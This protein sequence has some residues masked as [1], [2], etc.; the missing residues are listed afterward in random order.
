MPAAGCLQRARNHEQALTRPGFRFQ[1]GHLGQQGLGLRHLSETKECAAA[2]RRPFEE[3][4]RC[5]ENSNRAD[6]A[7][8]SLQPFPL[9]IAYTSTRGWRARCSLV[10]MH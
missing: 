5:P 1:L 9:L 4:A 10:D 2:R 3:V 7:A 6:V 8:S